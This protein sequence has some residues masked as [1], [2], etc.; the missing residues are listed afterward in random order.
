VVQVQQTIER[1][2]AD[3]DIHVAP[4]GELGQSTVPPPLGADILGPVRAIADGI[5]PK[6]A[7]VPTMTTGATDGRFLNAAGIPTYGISGMFQDA[8]G[9]HAHGLD[10]RLRVQSLLDGRRFLH[11]LV[12]RYADAAPQATA[13]K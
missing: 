8:E 7:I 13:S 4:V 2:L 3:Q 1:V 6:V 5:W 10:E 9:S 11:A 12:K